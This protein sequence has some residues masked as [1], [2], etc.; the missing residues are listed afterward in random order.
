MGREEKGSSP[1]ARREIRPLCLDGRERKEVVMVRR[2]DRKLV[3][4][5]WLCVVMMNSKFGGLKGWKLGNVVVEGVWKCDRLN[6][7]L[8]RDPV[9]EGLVYLGKGDWQ[10][11]N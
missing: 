7:R 5:V 4:R 11:L 10:G 9:S 8:C 1:C 2:S 6:G 3:K